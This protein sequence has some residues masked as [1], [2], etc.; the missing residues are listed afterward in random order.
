MSHCATIKRLDPLGKETI[1]TTQVCVIR[2][3]DVYILI[4]LSNLRVFKSYRNTITS[5]LPA[6]S[7]NEAA[8]SN[9]SSPASSVSG[10]DV[11]LMIMISTSLF[12]AM[13]GLP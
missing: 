7:D 1:E 4:C 12:K 6:T 2:H 3:Q 13:K 10:T 9:V 5:S 11:T 8:A